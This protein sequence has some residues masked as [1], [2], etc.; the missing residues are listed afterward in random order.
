MI[1]RIS[2]ECPDVR[3]RLVKRVVDAV[4]GGGRQTAVWRGLDED[5][6]Q[7]GSGVCFC[8]LR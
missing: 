7:A 4:Q 1:V 5:G 6:R 3:G 8:R 2:S